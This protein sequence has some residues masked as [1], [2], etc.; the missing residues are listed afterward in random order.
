MLVFTVIFVPRTT[1]VQAKLE[2][3]NAQILQVDIKSK[4][5]LI[6]EDRGEGKVLLTAD[7]EM[8]SYTPCSPI[9]DNSWMSEDSPETYPLQVHL[10]RFSSEGDVI[11]AILYFDE[12]ASCFV[13]HEYDE[14]FRFATDLA[15]AE[16]KEMVERLIH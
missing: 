14:I 2:N 13:L 12:K 1:K 8:R 6:L 11:S 15:N 10:D 4:D 16:T 7:G 5:Y 3:D 9:C